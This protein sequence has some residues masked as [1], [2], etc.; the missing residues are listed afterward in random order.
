MEA[1]KEYTARFLFECAICPNLPRRGSLS[2]HRNLYLWA[3]RFYAGAATT[4]VVGRIYRL[5]HR[6]RAQ[7][8]PIAHPH[9][10]PLIPAN[11]DN[12]VFH[13]VR[14]LSAV[15]NWVARAP[16]SLGRC[17]LQHPEDVG[18]RSS[19]GDC[20]LGLSPEFVSWPRSRPGSEV[21]RLLRRSG[22][23]FR[24]DVQIGEDSP[25]GHAHERCLSRSFHRGLHSS[26]GTGTKQRSD[27]LAPLPSL[28]GPRVLPWCS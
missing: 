22:L 3:V 2:A 4:P 18:P 11:V 7:P 10:V 6:P 24:R 8:L 5:V 20:S 19:M 21:A 17:R 28:R 15:Q 16:V 26:L 14:A 12:A 27:R 1:Q 25:S 23:L 9:M 13:R